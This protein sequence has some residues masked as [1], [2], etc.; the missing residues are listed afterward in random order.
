MM[1]SN[2]GDKCDQRRDVGRRDDHDL[3]LLVELFGWDECDADTGKARQHTQRGNLAPG[4]SRIANFGTAVAAPPPRVRG[5][6]RDEGASPRG[7]ELRQR[8]LTRIATQSDLSPRAV[9]GELPLDL[10]KI[11]YRA[12][13]G[14]NFVEKLQPVLA[15]RLVIDIDGDLVEEGV[16]CGTKC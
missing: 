12:R 8:P 4:S 11:R 5:E 15:Q 16:H 13:G 9:R 7:S 1:G 10:G 3:N 2:A 14:A 6:G